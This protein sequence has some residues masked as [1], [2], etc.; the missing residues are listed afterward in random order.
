VNFDISLDFN[1]NTG[2]YVVGVKKTTDA[3]Y[4]T[5]SGTL[6]DT[7]GGASGFGALAAVGFGNFNSG[8]D[9][10]LVVDNLTIVPEPSVALLGGIGVLALLRR[11]RD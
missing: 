5:V 9:Q 8:N 7:N 2:A 11:R 3:V 6:K 10:N 4:S 1:T